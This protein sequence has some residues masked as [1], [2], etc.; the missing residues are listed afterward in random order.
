MSLHEKENI[1]NMLKIV[2]FVFKQKK[3]MQVKTNMS[4]NK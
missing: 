3:F 2:S 1:P 4:K